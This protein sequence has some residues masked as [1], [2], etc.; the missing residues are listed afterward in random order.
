[1]NRAIDTIPSE[2]MS[3]LVA[4]HWPGN[5]REL[6][7]LIERAVILST[8]PVLNVPLN[9]L[10]SQPQAVTPAN[11]PANG[12]PRKIE[13]LEDVERR[14]VLETLEATGWV[15]GGPK[16]A[17]VLLGLKRSTLQVR[18]EKLGIRRARAA[19]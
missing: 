8:G 7:N 10:Q 19:E 1:M 11:A 2:T 9:D 18:M 17:A 16:G 15:V 13:T 6:Q 12:K 4:Y 3:V 14:H 5:I